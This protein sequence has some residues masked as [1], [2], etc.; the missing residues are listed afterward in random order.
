MDNSL[1]TQYKK[2]VLKTQP[3]TTASITPEAAANN[4]N[5]SQGKLIG[6]V[7]TVRS[8]YPVKNAKV[9]IFSGSLA[10]MNVI[11]TAFTDQSGR[12]KAFNLPTPNKALSFEKG[13]TALPYAVYNMQVEADGYI[14]NIHLGIPVFSETTSLQRSSLILKETA[15]IDKGPQIFDERQNYNL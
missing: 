5:I 3:F 7:D 10:Q 11:D 2:D 13:S 12:T 6:I 9:T 1:F 8:L 15:G 14:K 4:L